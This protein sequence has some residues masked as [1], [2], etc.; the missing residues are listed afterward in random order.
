M[1]PV[2]S[3]V[4]RS[5]FGMGDS[6][7]DAWG[8]ATSDPYYVDPSTLES[9]NYGGYLPISSGSLGPVDQYGNLITPSVTPTTPT[10]AG[11]GLT[12]AQ[13]AGLISGSASAAGT[14][15][16]STQS[17]SLIP[18]TQLVY[19]PA[20]GQMTSGIATTASALSS[21]MTPIILIAVIGLV[22]VMGMGKK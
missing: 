11:G 2:P 4:K 5:P 9:S 14:I 22:L 18:G 1:I 3:S 8:S 6:A 20:T 17:P 13:I 19:N 16:K 21:S 10:P 12:A 7:A 15:L